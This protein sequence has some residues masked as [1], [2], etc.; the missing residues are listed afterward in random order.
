[1]KHL[2]MIKPNMLVGDRMKLEGMRLCHA[3]KGVVFEPFNRSA[4]GLADLLNFLL[5]VRAKEL[6]PAKH[7][8]DIIG[9]VGSLLLVCSGVA[10]SFVKHLLLDV[11]GNI[12]EDL[13][14]IGQRG[15]T[16]RR[17]GW[18]EAGKEELLGRSRKEAHFNVLSNGETSWGF[19]GREDVF[20]SAQCASW[21]RSTVCVV[22]LG[23]ERPDGTFGIKR[24]FNAK[25]SNEKSSMTEKH[26]V[27]PGTVRLHP[28][29]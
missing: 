25:A 8:G 10:K 16:T 27:E 12:L 23:L 21:T 15:F 9:K 11:H 19:R 17:L 4:F 26:L 13:A 7:I 20:G 6:G 2:E 1:M 18:L 5:A 14:K 28:C 3:D 29:C 22:E 24:S